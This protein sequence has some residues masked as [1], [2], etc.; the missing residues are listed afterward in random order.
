M[1]RRNKIT[2]NEDRARLVRCHEEGSD[3]VTL[4][5]Q[6]GIKLTTAYSIIRRYVSSGRIDRDPVAGGRKQKLDEDAEDFLITHIEANP[7]ITPKELND[8]L[9]EI[10]PTKPHVSTAT[11][12]RTL[13]GQLI[14]LKKAN[15]VPA[16]RNREDVKAARIDYFHYM[17]AITL[18]TCT[19]PHLE[20]TAYT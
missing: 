13:D 20:D 3:F 1:P 4:A 17:Y 6:L 16:D 11:I 7:C 18:T 9:R 15:I 19:K 2:S 5:H 8:A 12:A 14:S 10:F